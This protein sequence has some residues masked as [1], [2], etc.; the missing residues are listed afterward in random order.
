MTDFETGNDKAALNDRGMTR[1]EAFEKA[2]A[3]LRRQI[4]ALEEMER[5]AKA[6]DAT[7]VGET[8]KA[9]QDLRRA[10]NL[11]GEAENKIDDQQRA[12]AAGRPEAI[13]LGA[14]RD[15]IGRRLDRL[16]ADGGP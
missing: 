1:E 15:E 11:F 14:A 12:S 16:R 10:L 7:V 3:G 5:R 4:E 13:D 6:G 2:K 9:L 8:P